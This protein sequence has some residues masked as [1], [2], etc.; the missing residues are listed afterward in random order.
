VDKMIYQLAHPITTKISGMW[1]EGSP[2]SKNKLYEIIDNALPPVNYSE[3]LL[4]PHSITHAEAPL[5]VTLN[6]KDILSFFHHSKYFFGECLVIRLKG[7]NYQ[8]QNNSKI[9]LW[10]I[11]LEELKQAIEETLQGKNFSGKILITSDFYP[12][13]INQMHDPNYVLIL[14]QEAADY[15]VSIDNFH[16]YGTSWKSSDFKPGSSERPIHKTLFKKAII[17]ELLN[18][19]DVPA[20][21]Y[22]Y[23]GVP[24]P[25]ENASESPIAPI[26]YREND[27]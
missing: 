23:S 2:Y 5:H 13:D 6:D 1:N 19:K 7:N 9:H 20:G 14:S 8:K 11:G 3:Y 4:K 25:L 10:E 12:L 26:L 21:I 15:L 27:R 16:L 17:V 22:Q 18:L 24:L